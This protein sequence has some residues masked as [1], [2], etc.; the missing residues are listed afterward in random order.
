MQKINFEKIEALD[1]QSNEAFKTLRTNIQFC[2]EKVKVISFTSC[3][4]NEGKSTMV[5][6]LAS[7]M[8]EAGKKVLMIDADIRKSVTVARYK[9]DKAA[10]GLSEYLTG[11][12]RLEDCLCSTN[13]ENMDIIFTGPVAPNPSELL[14][15]SEF[16]ELI[17]ALRIKYD[18]IFIDCPP[19]GSIIDAAIVSTVSDGAVFV[20]EADV[21]SYKFAQKVKQQLE[22]SGCKILGAVLNK[23]NMEG[24][25]YYGK[26]YGRYYG[27]KYGGYYK[28]GYGYGEEEQNAAIKESAKKLKSKKVKKV[29]EINK[30]TAEEAI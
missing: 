10:A 15:S 27:R 19:L 28:N 25:G 26:Y 22:K 1:F 8:G 18:Y 5:F 9:T 30:I 16:E 2:G 24:K 29:T 17:A 12:C 23:V 11:Q 3:L 14:G 7:S 6:R 21:I 4:P 13:L 20:I